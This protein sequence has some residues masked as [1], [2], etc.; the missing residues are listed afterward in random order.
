M[1]CLQREEKNG[2]VRQ[3]STKPE[4]RLDIVCSTPFLDHLR[5]SEP[6]REW[7]RSNSRPSLYNKASGARI[8]M[9]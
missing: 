9:H 8:F 3:D 7:D 4:A 1:N 5:H 6:H 2:N